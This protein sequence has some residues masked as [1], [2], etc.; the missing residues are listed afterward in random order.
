MMALAESPEAL[1]KSR[2]PQET[3]SLVLL[4]TVRDKAES[5]KHAAGGV[6]HK[7]REL[8]HDGTQMASDA[9]KA[10]HEK[11]DTSM[12]RLRG[13]V[14]HYPLAVGAG[15]TALGALAGVLF[16]STRRE[17]TA[18]GEKSD[19]LLDAAKEKGGAILGQGKEMALEA[20]SKIVDEA[21]KAG[22]TPESAGSKLAELAAT[23][24][25]VV[26][27]AASEIGGALLPTG[28]EEHQPV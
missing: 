17:D 18:F 12:E 4:A 14:D 26:R 5:W 13:A 27:N 1:R 19:A 2:L 16:P 10:I 21:A 6:S 3:R 20:G 7:G 15:F 9:G 11:Y 22:I 24:G 8:L 28:S 25:E 23:A